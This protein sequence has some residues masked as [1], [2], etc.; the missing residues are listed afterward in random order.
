M[1]LR[2]HGAS[3]FVVGR[4]VG[5]PDET[6]SLRKRDVVLAHFDPDLNILAEQFSS[7]GGDEPEVRAAWNDGVFLAVTA[8]KGGVTNVHLLE[9]GRW[10]DDRPLH[11]TLCPGGPNQNC[12]ALKVHMNGGVIGAGSAGTGGRRHFTG[13]RWFRDRFTTFLPSSG[14]TP[15]D[16][17]R[18]CDMTTDAA[19]NAIVTGLSGA[20]ILTLKVAF[21]RYIP[22]PD[23]PYRVGH[24]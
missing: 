10:Y 24:N 1:F 5:R 17:D 15:G 11:D 23:L 6:D 20:G 13:W 14:Y 22:P 19:G 3:T 16:D 8:R 18:A 2:H 9:Y 7:S 4:R 21:P 12:V